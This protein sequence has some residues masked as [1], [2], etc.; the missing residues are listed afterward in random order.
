MEN[1]KNELIEMVDIFDYYQISEEKQRS[2]ITSGVCFDFNRNDSIRLSCFRFVKFLKLCQ[3]INP[4]FDANKMFY[5]LNN[6][7]D[8]DYEYLVKLFIEMEN[9]EKTRQ[10]IKN[11]IQK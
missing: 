7:R 9:K 2:I 5:D 6:R 11:R 1:L 8:N 3:N 4:E 10:L